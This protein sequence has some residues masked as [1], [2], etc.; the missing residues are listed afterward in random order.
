MPCRTRWGGLEQEGFG[1]VF[2]EAAAAGVP[3]VAGRSGGAHEAVVHGETGAVVDPPDAHGTAEA[4]CALLE[5]ADR[6]AAM[7]A[8]ARERAETSFAYD[9]LAARLREALSA[10]RCPRIAFPLLFAALTGRSGHGLAPYGWRCP[11]S[12]L[13]LWNECEDHWPARGVA[14]VACGQTL[15]VSGAVR[16]TPG[17]AATA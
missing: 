1:I 9:V 10:D 6:R 2:L 11:I 17:A 16:R 13:G 12:S 8:A 7:G 5:D 15:L 14:W 4:L 3:Q